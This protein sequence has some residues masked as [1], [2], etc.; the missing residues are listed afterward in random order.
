MK[1]SGVLILLFFVS[2]AFGQS[3]SDKD[4]FVSKDSV[5]KFS[6]SF[7]TFNHAERIFNGT[8]RYLLTEST[9]KVTK[10][11]FGDSKSKIIYSKTIPK[12][13]SLIETI[14]KIGLDSLKEYY[15][16]N[17]IMIT[18]G[19]EYFLDFVN[20][21]TKKSISLHHYYLKQLDD[22]IQIINSHLPKKYQFQ[23][24]P[25]YTKQDCDL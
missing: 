9:I 10:T 7:S 25:N 22:I 23:Y 13:Q 19:D 17:C 20:G 11:F 6:I 21:S 2:V 15:F 16:N 18:S 12:A 8:T 14:N 4:N 3:Q 1:I 24:L 5:N